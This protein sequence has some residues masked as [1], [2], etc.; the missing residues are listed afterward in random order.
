MWTTTSSPFGDHETTGSLVRPSSK[1]QGTAAGL[2]VAS[3]CSKNDALGDSARPRSRRAAFAAASGWPSD[4]SSSSVSMRAPGRMR[5]K[6]AARYGSSDPSAVD[7]RSLMTPLKLLTNATSAPAMKSVCLGSQKLPLR[8]SHARRRGWAGLSDTASSMPRSNCFATWHRPRESSMP[9]ASQP[10]VKE[11]CMGALP[12]PW[13]TSTKI[14]SRVRPA[15]TAICCVA[16][17]RMRPYWILSG[18][19][20]ELVC[21]KSFSAR[22]SELLPLRTSCPFSISASLQRHSASTTRKHSTNS[23]SVR[24]GPPAESSAES[25]AND[26][27]RAASFSDAAMARCSSARFSSSS[28]ES[29]SVSSDRRRVRHVFRSANSF[30]CDAVD[31]AIA[32]RRSSSLITA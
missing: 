23:W 20:A 32:R 6:S 14:S 16:F 25:A 26:A 15:S 9:R 12:M 19:N 13:P 21:A 17:Q 2:T 30:A 8:S 5:E 29:P 22:E 31:S 7:D 24:H 27:R 10:I 11:S 18:T 4:G 3:R 28:D 1:A